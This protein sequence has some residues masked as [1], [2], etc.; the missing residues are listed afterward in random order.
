M[1]AFAVI[2]LMADMLAGVVS[3]SCGR[4][5]IRPIRQSAEKHGRGSEPLHGQSHQQQPEEG[6][7]EAFAHG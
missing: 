6:K 3:M 7:G 4:R 5:V 2:M 1:S